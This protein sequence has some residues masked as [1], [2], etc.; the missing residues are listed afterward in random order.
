MEWSRKSYF[1]GNEIIEAQWGWI[2]LYCVAIQ[3][4]A[5]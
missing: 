4:H 5:L 1:K 2:D 3:I